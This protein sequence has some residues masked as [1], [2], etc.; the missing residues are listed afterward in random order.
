MKKSL[1]RILRKFPTRILI[2]SLALAALIALSTMTYPAAQGETPTPIPQTPTI[3]PTLYREPGDTT[4]PIM[5]S[6]VL[7]LIIVVGVI[8]GQSLARPKKKPQENNQ[9]K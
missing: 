2:V 9:A 8:M 3:T 1:K 6:I 4:G 5:I 7:V